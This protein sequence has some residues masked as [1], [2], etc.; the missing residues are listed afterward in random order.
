MA[1]DTIK[2]RFKLLT[3]ALAALDMT[4]YF[5]YMDTE[6]FRVFVSPNIE[7]NSFDEYKSK[8][9]KTYQD[10]EKMDVSFSIEHITLLND[11]TASLIYK[12]DGTVTLNN[13]QKSSSVG[14]AAHIWVLKNDKWLVSSATI[15]FE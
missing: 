6:H 13:G 15:A 11:Q 9:L 8:Q 2:K 10:V 7:I 14:K 12:F 3:G 5:S 4:S 1:I